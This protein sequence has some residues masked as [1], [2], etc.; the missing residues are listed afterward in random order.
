[1]RRRPERGAVILE[2]TLVAI[3]ML[4]VMLGVV[5]YGYL[6]WSLSTATATAREA[7]RSLSVGTDWTCV[8]ERTVAAASSPAVGADDP[9]VTRAYATDGGVSQTA[10]V[11]G[12]RV[13]VTV[14]FPTLDMNLPFLPVPDGGVVSESATARIENVPSAALPC[15][16]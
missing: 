12:S 7:A 14:S 8:Q 9:T 6:Y 1:M 11:I 5:Q 15:D 16:G 2:F 10:P 3:V 4:A 13:T